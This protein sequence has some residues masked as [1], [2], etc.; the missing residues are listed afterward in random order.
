[1]NRIIVKNMT[2]IV[3][4]TPA[5]IVRATVAIAEDTTAAG[6]A[7][8]IP[9][10]LPVKGAGILV[11]DVLPGIKSWTNRRTQHITTCN[12]IHFRVPLGKMEV[13]P[14][15]LTLQMIPGYVP[16]RRC[17]RVPALPKMGKEH[18]TTAPIRTY[19]FQLMFA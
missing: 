2:A 1:M 8:E 12:G 19:I 3:S 5:P 4:Q 17:P 13:E 6:L 7:T 9:I 10:R 11:K 14:T 18:G 16:Q 15:V